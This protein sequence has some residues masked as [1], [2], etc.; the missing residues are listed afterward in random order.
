[1][2]TLS[3]TLSSTVH[4]SSGNESRT[5][6][7]AQAFLFQPKQFK[8]LRSPTFSKARQLLL[9]FHNY[10]WMTPHPRFPSPRTLPAL[11]LFILRTL[12][13]PHFPPEH[14][15]YPH[16]FRT[17]TSE[18]CFIASQTFLPKII[19]ILAN[20]SSKGTCTQRAWIMPGS[21][22]L[23]TCHHRNMINVGG[24]NE[25]ELN[26]TTCVMMKIWRWIL[27]LVHGQA[28]GMRNSK[29]IHTDDYMPDTVLGTPHVL[30]G[31]ILTRTLWAS[32]EAHWWRT[33]LPK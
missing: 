28:A 5:S 1:M 16:R 25:R 13:S 4:P 27:A 17:S 23:G 21:Q 14:L 3:R 32:Q 19:S 15:A 6:R 18:M 12:P 20:L 8:M 30:T 2:G 29:Q 24:R 7:S 33:H 31:L 22:D 26:G 9:S 11:H 10:S